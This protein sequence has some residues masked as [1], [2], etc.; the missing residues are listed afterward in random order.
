V[1]RVAAIVLALAVLVA[2]LGSGDIP[3]ALPATRDPILPIHTPGRLN[4]AV[5]QATLSR[6]VCV[7]GYSASIRPPYA[8]TEALKIRQLHAWRYPDTRP[9][10]YEED[11]FIPLSLGGAPRAPG[12]LWP[13]PDSQASKSD[14]LE[15]RLWWDVCH[16][17][18]KLRTARRAIAIYKRT[19]G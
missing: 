1:A 2:V 18:L 10:L 3:G 7:A 14:R 12:N 15:H 4:P 13:E 16:G 11:H 9:W 19:Y 17:V 8:Y 5:T 6:T